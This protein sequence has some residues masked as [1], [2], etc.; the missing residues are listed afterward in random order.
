MKPKALADARASDAVDVLHSRQARTPA[1]GYDQGAVNAIT[2]SAVKHSS[3]V[4][5][6]MRVMRSVVGV[7]RSSN[8]RALINI[9][10]ETRTGAQQ[11]F[12]IPENRYSTGLNVAHTPH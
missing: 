11:P 6:Q 12:T 9:F 5:K 1:G 8:L 4:T 3:V 10:M 7:G 2:M